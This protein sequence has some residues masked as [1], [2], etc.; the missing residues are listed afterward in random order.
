MGQLLNQF[1]NITVVDRTGLTDSYDYVVPLPV[2]GLRQVSDDAL[3]ASAAAMIKDLGLG[4]ESEMQPGE[5]LVVKT[6][7]PAAL[8]LADKKRLLLGPPNP[9]AEEGSKHWHHGMGGKACC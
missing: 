8:V 1:F 4:L 2:T 7:P 6:G 3:R 5:V 9:G